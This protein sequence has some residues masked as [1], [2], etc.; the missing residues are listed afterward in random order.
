MYTV[1]VANREKVEQAALKV[2]FIYEFF[3]ESF[4]NSIVPYAEFKS[5]F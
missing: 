4:P 1:D 3:N 5:N 2:L